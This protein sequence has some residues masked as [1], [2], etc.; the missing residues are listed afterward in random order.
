MAQNKTEEFYHRKKYIDDLNKP[1]KIMEQ[2]MKDAA[3]LKSATHPKELF[4]Q[5][6]RNT[7]YWHHYSARPGLPVNEMSMVICR[8][9]GCEINYCQL[10]KGSVKEEWEGTGDCK[11]E[12]TAFNSCMQ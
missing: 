7:T 12:I 2:T 8:D 5:C 10:L 3:S 9:L 6:L 1:N 4:S 11:D